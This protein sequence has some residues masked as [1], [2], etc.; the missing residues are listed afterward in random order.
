MSEEFINQILLEVNGKSITDF[1]TVTEGERELYAPVKLMNGTGHSKKQERPTVK[2]DY[3]IPSDTPEFDFTTV[4]GGTL[5]IDRQNGTRI[6]YT[7]VYTTKIGEAKYDAE[8]ECVIKAID[9]SS[10][11]RT[12]T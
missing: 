1:K 5:T 3:A 7:G 6:K 4:K 8:A 12:E 9:F 2:V 11:K 10:K